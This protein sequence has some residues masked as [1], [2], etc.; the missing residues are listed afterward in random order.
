MDKGVRRDRDSSRGRGKL[1]CG[2]SGGS[3]GGKIDESVDDE[4]CVV[5][6]IVTAVV[7]IVMAPAAFTRIDT[8]AHVPIYT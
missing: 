4:K 7:Q 3:D 5:V 6:M 8:R 2:G 1:V